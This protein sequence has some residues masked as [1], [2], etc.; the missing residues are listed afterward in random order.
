MHGYQM[1][2]LCSAALMVVA[3]LVSIFVIRTPKATIQAPD[4]SYSEQA[5]GVGDLQEHKDL[6]K[7]ADP[8][9]STR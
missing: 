2:F 7:E 5:S 6:Q 9:R 4:M 1:A 8:V 3:L